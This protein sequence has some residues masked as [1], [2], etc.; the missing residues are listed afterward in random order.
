M[1]KK[2]V[3]SV[4][5]VLDSVIK[6]WT[7]H[8]SALMVPASR[9]FVKPK[10]EDGKWLIVIGMDAPDTDDFIIG[11]GTTKMEAVLLATATLEKL[12]CDMD[13]MV[14]D[15]LRAQEKVRTRVHKPRKG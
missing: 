2:K 14:T 12:G 10:R 5:S 8:F 9:W 13:T 1:A 7:S 6:T 11:C 15:Y 4:E 3:G